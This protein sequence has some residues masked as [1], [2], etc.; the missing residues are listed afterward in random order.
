MNHLGIEVT[1]AEAVAAWEQRLHEQGM[2][3]SVQKNVTCCFAKQDKVWFTDPDGN[4]WEVFTVH[5]QLPVGGPLAATGC[6]V[7][8]TTAESDAT[9]AACGCR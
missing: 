6:C 2:V 8:K 1:D 4:S 5:E 9:A 7:P 3:E